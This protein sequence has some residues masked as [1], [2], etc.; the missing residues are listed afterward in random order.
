MK[1]TTKYLLLFLV[2]LGCHRVEKVSPEGLK[3]LV[4]RWRLVAQRNL[5]SEEKEWVEVPSGKGAFT[6][7]RYDGVILDSQGRGLCCGTDILWLNGTKYLIEPQEEVPYNEACRY[8]D[9]AWCPLWDIVLDGDTFVRDD[10]SRYVRM[11]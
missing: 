8:I 10:E 7:I 11:R 9:I 1:K 5:Q 3:P 4:G 2:L 6:I